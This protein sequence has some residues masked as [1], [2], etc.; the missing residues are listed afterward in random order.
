MVDKAS[1]WKSTG[2]VEEILPA[3]DAEGPA[4]GHRIAGA[5]P[6]RMELRLDPNKCEDNGKNQSM[7]IGKIQSQHPRTWT[8]RQDKG[9]HPLRVSHN[10]NKTDE[11]SEQ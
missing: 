6:D 10:P 4:I 2:N 1:Q 9:L 7:K 3:I 8:E 11:I 5:I